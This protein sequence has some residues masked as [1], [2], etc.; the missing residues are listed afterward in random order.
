MLALTLATLPSVAQ[1][2]GLGV[3]KGT[4]QDA[5]GAVIPGAQ[6]TLVNQSTNV[7]RSAESSAVGTYEFPAVPLGP[8]KLATELEGFKK[9]EGT[10]TL[11]AGQ[12]AV[13]DPALEVGSVDIVV[14][15]S[16]VAAPITTTGMEISDVKDVRRIR[17]LPLNGRAITNLFNLSPGVEGGGNPRTNGMKVGSTE[18]LL[19]GISLVDRFGGGMSRV[20]PGLDTVE[21]FRIETVGSN[22]RNSRPATISIVTRSGTNDFHGSAFETHRNNFGGLRARRREDGNDPAQLIRNEFGVSA[23]GSIIRNRTFWFGAYEASRDRRGRFAAMPVPLAHM[24]AGDLSDQIDS[25]GNQ[26]ITYDPLT[27]RTDGT[28]DPFPNLTIPTNRISQFGKLMQEQ[29]PLPTNSV[30]PFFGDNFENFYPD[31]TD[32]NQYMIKIDHHLSDSDVINGRFTF[33]KRR[34]DLLGGRFGAPPPGCTN[35]GGSGRSIAKVY[36]SM[37][38]WNHTFSP[39]VLNEFQVSNH[40]SPKTSGTQ[41]DDTAWADMLGLPNPFDVTGWPTLCGA[42]PFLFRGW[43]CWDGDNRK[44]E[45]LTAWQI[46]DNVNWVKGNHSMSFGG[47]FRQEYNNIRELQQA[48]GS[49]GFYGNW[50]ELWDPANDQSVSFTGSELATTMLGLGTHLRNQ[51]NRGFFY[52]EQFEMGLYFHDSWKISP[53][54]TLELGVRYDRWA[55]YG[56]KNDRLVN[57]DLSQFATQFQVIT[58]G[59]TRVEDV[60]GILPAMVQSYAARGLTWVTADSI[61]FP[62]RLLPV[63]N[64]NFGPRIG[65]AHRLTDKLVL[66]AGYGEYY[67]TM[68]LSQIL[69]SARTNPPFNLR[70]T[71]FIHDQNGAEPDYARKN[72]PAPADF[73]ANA[74]VPTTGIQGLSSNAMSMRSWDHRDWR[75]DRMQSWHFTL[76]HEVMRDTALR[77]SYIGNHGRNLEQKFGLNGRG[78]EWNYQART[79]LRRPGTR[80]LMRVNRDWNLQPTNHTGFSNSQSFQAEIERRYSNGLAFQWFYTFNHTLTTTD[81][82]GFTSGGGSINATGGG[83]FGVPENIDLFGEPSLSYDDRLRLGYYNT[84][85]IPAHRVRWNGIYDLPFGKGQKF[86]SGVGSA[87]NHVIGGWQLAT[88]GTWAS[89]FWTGVSS[90]RYLFG[91]PTLS[92]SERPVITFGGQTQVVFFAGD[93]NSANPAIGGDVAGLQRVINPDRSQRI[94]RPLGTNFNN[95]LPQQLADGSIVQTGITDHVNWNPKNFFRG[96]GRWNTDISLF[97]TFDITET[98]NARFSADFFNAFN[99]PMNRSPSSTSGLQNL[100]RQANEPRIIQ[101]SL[102]F[103]W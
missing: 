99:A 90:G 8:Y 44:D 2:T 68:P 3:V 46:D 37:L 34:N 55:P 88:I 20:Q 97:K 5:T 67:W 87:A 93:F 71:N 69:Q 17:Q 22:A 75:D 53:R 70:F 13:V 52:F 25:D 81:A 10:F 49:H 28:R 14:E 1:N 39:T 21:E 101:F 6:V 9:W 92:E 29:T 86:G 15:V 56:E 33:N 41:G 54:T 78:S 43:G 40:R 60:Q 63:D 103:N 12:T 11:Q 96:P 26:F 102:R 76:E 35:C 80:D 58:P 79:G 23:G 98:V 32:Q 84:A 16:G 51:A 72:V 83:N 31:K 19:D 100:G 62:S 61:G 45:N 4:V 74:I 82:G 30:N 89:G 7:E 47:K 94:L 24:W 57:M 42:A 85:N 65:M 48:Q 59:S 73:L 18:M 50:T 64:N 27:T 95:R 36:S 66:R 77:L 38:R 91:D